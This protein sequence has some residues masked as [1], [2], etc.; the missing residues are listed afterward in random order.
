MKSWK[1]GTLLV[2]AI[3][4]AVGIAGCNTGDK[5]HGNSSSQT[6]YTIKVGTLSGPHSEFAEEVKKVAATK[7]LNIEIVEFNDYVQPNEAL[8]SGEIDANMY[9]HLPYLQNAIKDR[10]Y[11]LSS[12]GNTILFPMG[13][14]SNKIKSIDEIKDNMIVAIPNDPSNGGRALEILDKAKVIQLK[15]E[16]K[17]K[18][19][20]NDIVQ[21]PHHLQ[22][23]EVDAAMIPR[24]LPDLDF[25]VINNSY[26]VKSGLVPTK[27]A[28]ILEGADSPYANIAVV[29]TANKE[30]P[31]MK[32]LIESIQN[33]EVKKFV[34]DHFKGS[35]IAAW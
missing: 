16:E 28:F 3:L 1:V 4:V 25:A 32:L 22:I 2:A 12:L 34:K 19:T 8:N 24:M 13:V 10:G 35:A 11:Q 5:N 17:A 20:V 31:E 7:G 14:Y 6:S 9:Q 33:D 27:D 29:R 30:K 23:Q 18:A 21:N 15:K 26:A